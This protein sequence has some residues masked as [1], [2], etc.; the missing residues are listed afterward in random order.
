[1]PVNSSKYRTDPVVAPTNK[2]IWLLTQIKI[3][4]R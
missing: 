3:A 4:Q 1:L 2:P